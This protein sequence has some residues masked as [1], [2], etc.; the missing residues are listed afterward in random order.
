MS[1]TEFVNGQYKNF[2][3]R[4]SVF[5]QRNYQL[6]GLTLHGFSRRVVWGWCGETYLRVM[7]SRG[8]RLSWVVFWNHCDGILGEK[9]RALN[10][11]S[12]PPSWAH[13]ICP[14]HPTL[15]EL[16]APAPS[17]YVGSESKQMK[18]AKTTECLTKRSNFSNE[19]LE[20]HRW[21][22]A[23]SCNLAEIW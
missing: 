3:R 12:R 7:E 18:M 10:R 2:A 20:I 15:W 17:K 9:L 1:S 4:R 19:K 21:L 11:V 6:S 8:V 13:D 14:L 16:Y 5:T 23:S 22:A